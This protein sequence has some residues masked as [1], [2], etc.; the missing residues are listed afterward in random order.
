[1]EVS[2]P[3]RIRCLHVLPPPASDP[4]QA[5]DR[6]A[7]TLLVYSTQADS[8]DKERRHT[9]TLWRLH[10]LVHLARQALLLLQDEEGR[11]T[12]LAAAQ[13][14]HAALRVAGGLDH[15]VVE[16]GTRGGDGD[17]VPG[18]GTKEGRSELQSQPRR[19]IRRQADRQVDGYTRAP[20]VV[21]WGTHARSWTA[22]AGGSTCNRLRSPAGQPHPPR[23][24]TTSTKP[25][26]LASMEPRSPSLPHTPGISPLRF[27]S[28][29]ACTTTLAFALLL[30]SALS[31]AAVVR[32][33]RSFCSS[34]F[35][36]AADLSSCCRAA[37]A[38]CLRGGGVVC[39]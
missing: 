34:A 23:R 12:Q 33:P 22:P 19:T 8:P 27:A 17:V 29:S 6:Q 39:V 5:K 31:P 18:G 36:A 7:D 9:L 15:D 14:L 35:S 24:H 20:W 1:M 3:V 28:S 25:A 26:H 30:L 21:P 32:S 38:A 13:Q 4:Y 11:H 37:S 16:G 2:V 10:R